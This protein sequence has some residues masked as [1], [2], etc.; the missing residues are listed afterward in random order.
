MR[1]LFKSVNLIGDG[2]YIGP[3]LRAWLKK[4]GANSLQ[5]EIYLWTLNDHIAPLY[6]GMVRDLVEIKTVFERP[7]G[8]FKFEHTF[9]V[10]KAFLVSNDKKQHL[11]DSYADLLNVKLEGGNE[12]LK[13]IYIPEEPAEEYRD[14]IYELDNDMI[15]ISAFSASCSGRDPKVGIPNK[16]LPWAKW[17]PM[18][19]LLREEFPNNNIRFLGAPADVI[20]DGYL[21]KITQP[22]EYMRGIPLNDLAL[23]MKRAK[24]L[25][26]VDN[27]MSHLGASQETPTFLFYPRCLGT[28]YIL[29]I[30]NPN[31]SYVHMDPVTVNPAQLRFALNHFIQKIK[32]KE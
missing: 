17:I 24:L 30:G 29:P 4:A 25:V 3:A 7:Q 13:P 26:T 32:H 9:D 27:G 10:N 18:L 5:D 6:Q 2:L 11:A 20:P 12:R 19:N 23:I 8:E 15:L 31:M 14:K 1:Y 22:G 21:H 16:M 28:H